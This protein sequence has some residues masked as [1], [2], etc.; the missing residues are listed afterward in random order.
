MYYASITICSPTGGDLLPGGTRTRKIP[1]RPHA[2]GATDPGGKYAS[3]NS[4]QNK[5]FIVCQLGVLLRPL[6]STSV[7]TE[8]LNP[9]THV[10]FSLNLRLTV[11]A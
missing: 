2:S 6:F 11:S 5:V 8:N 10:N 3:M 9:L 1:A 7:M 4:K